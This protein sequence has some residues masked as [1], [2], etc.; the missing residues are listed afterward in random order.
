MNTSTVVLSSDAYELYERLRQLM[1]QTDRHYFNEN[2]SGTSASK[3]LI[4]KKVASRLGTS[5]LQLEGL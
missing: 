2:P 5:A 4:A 3:E 1:G